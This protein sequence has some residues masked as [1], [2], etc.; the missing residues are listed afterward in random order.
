MK[1]SLDGLSS[2]KKD[3]MNLKIIRNTPMQGIGRQIEEK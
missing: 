2:E 1:N 3:S